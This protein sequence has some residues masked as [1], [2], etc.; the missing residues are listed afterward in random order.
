VEWDQV[1]SADLLEASVALG[2]LKAVVDGALVNIAER[3]EATGAAEAIGWASTKVFLTHVTGGRKGAGGGIVR[4]AE[5]AAAL[6]AVRAALTTGEISL[7]Q[8][9]V[10]TRRVTTLP[11]VPELRDAAAEKMLDRVAQRGLDA[12]DLDHCFGEVVRE[13]DPDG[14]LLGSERSKGL[15]RCGSRWPASS[16]RES[17]SESGNGTVATP[18]AS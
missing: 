6:P 4:V 8:A 16:H 2:R 7:A 10:I 3:L 5:R 9:S 14:K 17:L 15:A 11:R 12:S 1:S 18:T 13:L